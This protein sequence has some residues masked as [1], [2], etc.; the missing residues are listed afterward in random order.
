MRAYVARQEF[1]EA[2]QAAMPAVPSKAVKPVLQSIKLVAGEGRCVLSATDLE[3]G[4][5]VDAESVE[6]HEPGVCLLPAAKMLEILKESRDVHLWIVADDATVMVTSDESALEF[7][8]PTEAAEAFPEV[9]QMGEGGHHTVN[10]EMLSSLVKRT[11]F[12][13]ADDA[14]RYSMQGVRWAFGA[15]GHLTLVATD[16]RRL[17]IA[18][19]VAAA[20][21][22]SKQSSDAVVP[23][24]AMTM[25]AK[26]VAGG[27]DADDVKFRLSPN[28]ALFSAPGVTLYS[29]LVEGRFPDWKAVMPKETPKHVVTAKVGALL[30]ATRQASV[31]ADE[32]S[33]RV[34]LTFSADNLTLEA[35]PA[36]GGRS[37]VKTQVEYKGDGVTANLNPEYLI[38]LLR[39][40][41]ADADVV[42]EMK[43]GGNPVVFKCGEDF[44]SLLMPLT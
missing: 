19:G 44:T 37:H 9:P 3:I 7:V 25:L 41:P 33:A 24:K 15:G 29:R 39:V 40:L 6:I 5:R 28:E 16:G 35:K 31:M 17:A 21:G 11:V 23:A 42:V 30:Q 13:C 22:D 8:L 1:L 38:E 26:L 43:D 10:A 20:V 18:T 4:V 14:Q 12:C 2:C 36:G 34:T 27:D 32:D